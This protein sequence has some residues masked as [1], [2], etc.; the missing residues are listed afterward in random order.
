MTPFLTKPIQFYQK[1]DFGIT[2]L[3][4]R[5]FCQLRENE[6]G[7]CANQKNV[8]SEL[9]GITRNMPSAIS[10]DFIENRP[11]LHFLPGS[12]VLCIGTIGCNLHCPSCQNHQISQHF[13]QVEPLS[14]SP[15]EIVK[16]ALDQNIKIISFGYNEPIIYY[17][18]AKEIGLI[19]KDKGIKCVM[20]TSAY[21]SE[22]I[23]YDMSSWLDAVHVDLKSF[24]APYYKNILGAELCAIKENLEILAH[25]SLWLEITTLLIDGINDSDEEVEE[26]AS[27]IDNKLGSHIPWHLS[28][29]LPH[30]QMLS[31]ETTSIST[32]LNAYEIAKAHGLYHVYFGNL[33]FLNESFCPSCNTLLLQRR[34]EEVFVNSLIEGACPNCHRPLEGVWS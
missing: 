11:F 23:A 26:I 32:V 1:N 21:M 13:S 9:I 2:C 24:N 6:V 34:Y 17:P 29:F 28:I 4:C 19:A 7:Q 22:E 8:D 30:N 14:L 10:I 16:L 27:F 15:I 3:I 5:H 20:Q 25:S 12:S 18:Y 33:P 31:T